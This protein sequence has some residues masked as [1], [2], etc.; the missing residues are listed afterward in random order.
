M[1]I[2]ALNWAYEQSTGGPAPK[3]VLTILADYAD[4]NGVSYPSQGNIARKAEVS[5]SS[6]RR[7]IARLEELNLVCRVERFRDDGARSSDEYRLLMND[8]TR[9]LARQNGWQ[10][11]TGEADLTD[12]PPTNLTGGDTV[13]CGGDPPSTGGGGHP[14]LVEGAYIEPPKEPIPPTPHDR[15]PADV[16]GKSMEGAQ[17]LSDAAAWQQFERAWTVS[18]CDW[19]MGAARKLFDKLSAEDQSAAI[20][21]A[22]EYHRTCAAA[23]RAKNYR[24]AVST[25][26][27][28]REWQSKGKAGPAVAAPSRSVF[29]IYEGSD[30]D[31]AWRDYDRSKGITLSPLM[32]DDRLPGR[33][34]VQYQRRASLWPPGHPGA[35]DGQSH[36]QPLT[37]TDGARA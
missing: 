2:K 24:Q 37:M 29:K 35:P 7:H 18:D 1:S 15:E 14:S 5:V 27:K 8:R 34:T 19:S 23:G 25:W 6:I 3:I 11:R 30:Q 32:F 9:D 10:E 36:G 4:E 21:G 16:Q 26:L 17:T 20:A 22:R 33:G 31:R 28:N 13:T 12:T